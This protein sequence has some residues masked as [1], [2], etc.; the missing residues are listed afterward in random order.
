MNAEELTAT[1]AGLAQE[2]LL[3]H[4]DC[5]TKAV[6]HLVQVGPLETM[7]VS[8][9]LSAGACRSMK[10]RAGEDFYR[11]ALVKVGPDGI[12]RPHPVEEAPAPIRIGLQMGVACLNRDEV[13]LMSLWNGHVDGDAAK[14]VELLGCLL[15]MYMKEHYGD[16]VGPGDP[17][18]N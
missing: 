1:L 12:R 13:T 16:L 15:T 18:G 3:G 17:S 2:Y 7:Q 8:A 5:L 10:K 9:A 4:E 6:D 11:A 14:A